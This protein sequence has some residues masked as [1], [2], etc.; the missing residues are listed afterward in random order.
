MTK[1]EAK[2]RHVGRTSGNGPIGALLQMGQ[3]PDGGTE[4]KADLLAQLLTAAKQRLV[5]TIQIAPAKGE[6]LREGA[7]GPGR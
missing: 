7:M 6:C 5:T 2:K 1:S 4:L 3:Q